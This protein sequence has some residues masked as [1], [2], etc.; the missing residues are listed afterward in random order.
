MQTTQD[1]D[2]QTDEQLAAL[3][4]DGDEGAF[5]ALFERYFEDIHD[6][7]IRMSRDPDAAAAAVYG[8]FADAW[9]GLRKGRGGGNA[10]AWLF[11]IA[12]GR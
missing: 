1:Y 2:S 10:K 8:T 7:A 4:A 6:F 9:D 12:R 5:A 3:A 11:A